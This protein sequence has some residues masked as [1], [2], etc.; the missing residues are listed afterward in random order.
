MGDMIP[1][2]V[3]QSDEVV[4]E[5]VMI[6]EGDRW[7]MDPKEA[8]NLAFKL[9]R[10]AAKAAKKLRRSHETVDRRRWRREDS[11]EQV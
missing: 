5:V 7:E 2:F 9:Y 4:G 10:V 11:T 6:L 3:R 8:M 1:V